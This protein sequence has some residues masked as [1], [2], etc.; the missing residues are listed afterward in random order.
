MSLALIRKHYQ[1]TLPAEIRKI[2]HCAEGDVID[3][4]VKKGEV[5]L[6]PKM[7]VD[8]DQAWFWTK[9]WQEG[10][11]EADEDIKKGRVK[12]F[13]KMEDLIEDLDR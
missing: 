5:I 7:L 10:E 9:E 12:K 8:K 1:I 11:R 2:L 4:V 3:L 6:K 13:K